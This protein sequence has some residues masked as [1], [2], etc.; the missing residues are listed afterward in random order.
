M[1][2]RAAQIL[3]DPEGAAEAESR[4][5][6]NPKTFLGAVRRSVRPGITAAMILE[7]SCYMAEQKFRKT[8]LA[9]AGAIAADGLW[10]WQLDRERRERE[11]GQG[12]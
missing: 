2:G 7:E 10:S 8:G 3:P 4:Q 5:F 11:G 6:I 12:R 9:A 1:P